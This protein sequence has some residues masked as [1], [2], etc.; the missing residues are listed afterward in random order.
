MFTYIYSWNFYRL[1][2]SGFLLDFFFKKIVIYKLYI[3]YIYSN[4][5]FSEKYFIEY[6]F[7]VLN[8]YSLFIKKFIEYIGVNF[9]IQSLALI[10]FGILWL[11]IG[12]LI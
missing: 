6:N 7:L 11:S 4:I 1:L 10:I 2:K 12:L 5:Y 3:L 8:S 9:I